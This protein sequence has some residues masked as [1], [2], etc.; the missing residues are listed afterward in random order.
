[1]KNKLYT[2]I[3]AIGLIRWMLISGIMLFSISVNAQLTGTLN[4]PGAYPTLADAIT[5]LNTQG[6]GAGGVTLNLLAGNPQLAPVG[7]Y[8]IGNTGSLVLTSTSFT[9][10]V[11]L[12]GNGNTITAATGLTPGSLNDGIF[13]LI[14]ADYITIDGFTL[15]ENGANTTTAHQSDDGGHAHIDIPAVNG[16]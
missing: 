3:T 11:T 16:E 4:I 10:Q 6:V 2:K 9:A 13:K 5:D 15:Q 7:G 14:G 12:E 8:V 1:M